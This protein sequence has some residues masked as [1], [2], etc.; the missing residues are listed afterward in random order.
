MS[1]NVAKNGFAAQVA[2]YHHT[3][4]FSDPDYASYAIDGNF[5][6]DLN[7]GARCAVTQ[8]W[9]GA[10]WQVDLLTT[11]LVVKVAIT[12][13]KHRVTIPCKWSFVL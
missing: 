13:R 3:G 2:D 8:S 9:Y 10:W 11:N 6:T 5:S 7:N 12:T 4:R 1:P